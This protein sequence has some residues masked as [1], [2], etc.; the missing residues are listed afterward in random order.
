MPQSPSVKTIYYDLK[1]LWSHLLPKRRLQ[2]SLILILMVIASIAEIVSIGAVLPFLGVLT[3]PEIIFEH[4]YS[5]KIIHL[6]DISSPD[7][8]LL[9]VTILFIIVTLLSACIRVTLLYL[10]T[11]LSFTTGSDL[12]V[13]IYRKTL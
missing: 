1:R 3:N 10:T 13:D 4:E 7:Q 8:L 9:P 5:Q 2:A 6:L 12:S 11:K